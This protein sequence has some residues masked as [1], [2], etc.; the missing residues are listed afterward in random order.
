MK[1]QYHNYNYT[2]EDRAKQKYYTHFLKSLRV[3]EV[4]SSSTGRV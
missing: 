4:V 2:Y 1:H 3:R